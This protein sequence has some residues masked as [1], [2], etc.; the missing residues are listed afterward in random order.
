MLQLVSNQIKQADAVVFLTTGRAGLFLTGHLGSGLVVSRL[1]E[2]NW[3]A[4]SS[5][6]YLGTGL[7]LQGGFDVTDYV[8]ILKRQ[9]V[10][11]FIGTTQCVIHMV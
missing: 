6:L 3:S 10:D 11:S 5:I 9:A 7:G 1:G 4:P 2:S 8:I